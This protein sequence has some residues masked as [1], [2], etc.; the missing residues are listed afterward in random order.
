MGFPSGSD[1]KEFACKLSVG[2][3]GWI[4]GLERPPEKEIATHFCILD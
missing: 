2:D 1:G 4:P 3:L